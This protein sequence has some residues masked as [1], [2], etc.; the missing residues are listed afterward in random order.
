VVPPDRITNTRRRSEKVQGAKDCG[1]KKGSEER[2]CPE[3]GKEAGG[4]ERNQAT[5]N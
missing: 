5:Q 2:K 4:N 1:W 3:F